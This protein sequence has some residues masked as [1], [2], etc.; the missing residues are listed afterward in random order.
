MK[1]LS[2]LIVCLFFSISLLSQNV[3]IGIAIPAASAK[4]HIN[5]TTSGLLIPRMTAGQRAA[6]S[7][8]A[9]GLLVY[10]TDATSGFYYY[11]GSAWV[12]LEANGEAWKL[13]GNAGS[14]SGTNFLGTTDN[15][16]LDIRTNNVIRARITTK[17]QIEILNTGQSVFIGQGAG[18]NDDLST[19]SNVFIGQLAGNQ[20]TTGTDNIAIGHSAYQGTSGIDNIAIGQYTL[21]AN[22]SQSGNIA[23]GNNA[24]R[25]TT[26]G[27]SNIGIGIRALLNNSTG[28][29]NMAIGGYGLAS[30]TTGHD[31]IS[32]GYGAMYSNVSGIDN[33]TIGTYSMRYATGSFNVCI[34]HEANRY[35]QAG[36]GNTIIGAMAGRGSAVHSKSW[37]VFIGYYAGYYETGSSL[38]YIDNSSTSSP[39]LWGDFSGNILRINGTF[40][41]NDPALAGYAFPLADGTSGY[42]LSTNGS[43]TVTWSDPAG[44]AS[45]D[46]SRTGNS[47]TLNG[48]HFLGTTDNQALDIRTNNV[49][50]ARFSTQGQIEILNTGQ[51]VFVGEGAGASDD[52]SANMNSFVGYRS[53]YSNITGSNNTAYGYQS[54]YSNT[55]ADFNTAVGMNALY[56]NTIGINN[57]ASGNS[58][59]DHNIS[60]SNNTAT[61]YLSSYLNTSGENNTCIGSKASMYNSTASQNVA[62]G[63]NA[64]FTQSFSNGGVVW[65]SENVALGYGSLYNNQPTLT[66]N[67]IQNTAVGNKSMYSNTTGYKTATVGYKALYSNTTGYQHAVLGHQALYHNTTG[68][69]NCGIGYEVLFTNAIGGYNAGM[70]YAALF[71]NTASRNTAI[72]GWAAYNNSSG[73]DNTAIA[74]HSMYANT[75]GYSNTALGVNSLNANTSGYGNSAVGYGAYSSGTAYNNSSALGYNTAIT[76]SNQIRLGNS[77]VTSIGGQVAWTTLSDARFKTEIK[78]DVPGLD[79]IK[80]LRPVSYHLDMDKL[81]VFLQTPDSLRDFKQERIRASQL[82]TGFIAQ[83]VE[84]ASHAID[85]EFN[86]VDAPDN[87]SDFYGLRYAGFVV[88][89]VKGMQEQQDEIEQLKA[90]NKWLKQQNKEIL[91]RLEMLENK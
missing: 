27:N 81:A 53:G 13:S 52:L 73:N 62:I 58:A 77:L 68:I 55:T 7:T 86:G 69:R 82:Q 46:W 79:F 10:Q 6:I 5:S 64:L 88:P 8:P 57:V 72:G 71:Y 47:G 9:T 24:L 25:Y 14:L 50:H 32:I 85:Y 63:V 44:L 49:I 67:G 84:Q 39:L 78:D 51:S 26:T 12:G 20:N 90:E 17:G 41:V 83:E 74:Y 38:L 48:T 61:G 33:I 35:N 1:T 37:N 3:G 75:T 70:G 89:L 30:N 42:V 23:L 45:N 11:T 29:Y 19:N 22:G 18:A 28:Y 59:L 15:Q 80:K 56:K 31:N 16:A 34:G 65:N 87:E 60:G 91:K 43:G 40:Q 2:I 66:S 54:L 36:T 21:M 76:A 4:L